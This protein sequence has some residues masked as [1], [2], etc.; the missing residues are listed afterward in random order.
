[1]HTKMYNCTDL[2]S[3]HRSPYFWTGIR[4]QAYAQTCATTWL[5][6]DSL[7]VSDNKHIPKHFAPDEKNK[8]IKHAV[9]ACFQKKQWHRIM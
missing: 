8:K 3:L 5:G 9:W 1:M 4:M 7:K 2:I 6:I